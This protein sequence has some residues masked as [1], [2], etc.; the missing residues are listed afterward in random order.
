[1]VRST[2]RTIVLS[3]LIW[4]QTSCIREGLQECEEVYFITIKVVDMLTGEDITASREVSHAI[5][6]VFDADEQYRYTVRAD[7]N[8]VRQRIPIPITLKNTDHYWLS[9]WGNLDGNQCITQLEPSNTLD[10]PTVSAS[11]KEGENQSQT[12]DDLFFGIAQI[13]KS[14]IRNEEII[15][16]R[17]N[18]RMY[19][20]VRGLPALHKAIDYYFTIHLNNNGYNFKGTPIP[21][22]IVIKQNG[23]TLANNDFV[24]PS[25]FNLIHTDSSREDYATVNLY[26]RSD[27]EY[28]EDILIASINSDL[29]GNPIVLPA[30]RT[31][32][33]LIDLRQEISVHIKTSLWDKTEQWV[34]W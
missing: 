30:G 13:G 28:G 3:L 2:I 8:Q 22:A 27:T 16:S 23:I 6:F 14:P 15:I 33:L 26:R 18:A 11:G 7:S 10:N 21:N 19:L 32:N 1:M 5:L 12:Q 4:G 24:S 9:V 29:N 20:T 25:S 31:T 17:K 34:E